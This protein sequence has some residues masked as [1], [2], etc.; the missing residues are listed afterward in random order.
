MKT[1]IKTETRFMNM[2]NPKMSLYKQ[3]SIENAINDVSQDVLMDLPSLAP[4]GNFNTSE[5]TTAAD[6]NQQ[7]RTQKADE[8][9]DDNK[10]IVLDLDFKRMKDPHFHKN[11]RKQSTI[12]MIEESF[13]FRPVRAPVPSLPKKQLFMSFG[14][15]VLGIVLLVVGTSLAVSKESV[16]SGIAFWIIGAICGLPGLFYVIKFFQVCYARS[17]ENKRKV[18]DEIPQE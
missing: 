4:F 6:S 14:L 8:Y 1:N 18:L 3:R 13:K 7:T 12:A 15:L 16:S 5:K 9:E 2:D 11:A 17:G 10:D